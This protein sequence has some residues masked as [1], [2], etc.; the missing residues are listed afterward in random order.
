[1]NK[2]EILDKLTKMRF[3]GFIEALDEQNLSTQYSDLSF[4]ERLG[5]LIER[6]YLRREN[7]K[8][9]R[10]V[11]SA[12][13]KHKANVSEISFSL[14]RKINKTLV[15]ELAQCTW[16]GHRQNLIITGPT[17]VG[18]TFIASALADKAC[19]LGF[20]ALYMKTADFISD[21]LVAHAEGTSAKLYAKLAKF[22]LL[23][24]DEWLR[25]ALT[26]QAL[27]D[28]LDLIDARHKS[29]SII[30]LS[31]LNISDWYQQIT[32]PTIADA[33]LDRIVHNSH[34]LDISGDTMRKHFSTLKSNS[35][36]EF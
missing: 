35:P 2:D 4:D 30:F 24:L 10:R 20:R 12:K 29:A 13:L 31:Q 23:I 18:K 5:F 7:N 32:E 27:R 17:G 21:M 28:V 22:D 1:M 26:N 11:L 19:R 34:R 14:E 15:L 33:L 6:E 3:Y 16:I 25:D 8:I 36:T 9:N